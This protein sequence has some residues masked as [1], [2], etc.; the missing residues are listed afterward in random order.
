MELNNTGRNNNRFR[1]HINN[2]LNKVQT[3][4][5]AGRNTGLLF[6]VF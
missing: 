4:M 1:D 5:S 6:Y 3:L 2:G